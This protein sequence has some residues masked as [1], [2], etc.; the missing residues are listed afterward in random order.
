MKQNLKIDGWH[1]NLTFSSS[2]LIIDHQHCG[3][4]H[5]H[6]YAVS[7]YLKGSAAKDGMIVDFSHLKTLLRELIKTLDHKLLIPAHDTTHIKEK[8][9][10]I[11]IETTTKHYQIPKEDCVLLPLPQTTAEYLS[12]YLLQTLLSRYS[13]PKNVEIISLGISEG[14]GQS[15]WSSHANEGC[16]S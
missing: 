10:I 15:A 2:H 1:N 5:G 13:P 16:T 14:P 7:L 3:R 6:T 12:R 11:H 4:L 8:N 9:N